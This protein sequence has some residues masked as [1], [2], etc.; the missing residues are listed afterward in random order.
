MRVDDKA[1]LRN[2]NHRVFRRFIHK[3]DLFTLE[4]KTDL[5]VGA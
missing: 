4:I 1:I 2:K 5:V 3:P